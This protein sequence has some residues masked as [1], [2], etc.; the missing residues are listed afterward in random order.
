MARRHL[1]AAG[2]ALAS[3]AAV[4]LFLGFLAPS[5]RAVEPKAHAE[6]P[7]GL[8]VLGGSSAAAWPLARLVYADPALRPA[9]LDDAHA[10]ALA[11]ES[12]PGASADLDDLA[13][14]RGAIHGDDAASRR[15]LA[16][17]SASLH[18]R[19]VVVV[20]GEPSLTGRPS[21]R[22]FLASEEA[23]DAAHYDADAPAPVTWGSGVAAVSW[24]GAAE[25]LHRAYGGEVPK[26]TADPVKPV[27]RAPAPLPVPAEG[28]R[29]FYKSPWFWAA[30]GAAAFGAVAVYLATRNDGSGNIQLQV[31][32]PR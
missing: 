29:P 28:S 20:E 11:G 25:S 23:F 7:R 21:A 3:A 9:G 4:V 30:A 16:S 14:I 8:A 32:V 15:L 26:P 12:T 17:L 13:Q 1:V 5:A 27:S 22:V 6:E 31:Q 19:G 24:R 2:R 10:H 18:V